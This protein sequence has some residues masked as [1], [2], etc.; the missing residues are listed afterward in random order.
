MVVGMN[1]GSKLGLVRRHPRAV[2]WVGWKLARH[3][4][5]TAT[6]IK[7]ARVAPQAARR[8]RAAAADPRLQGHVYEGRDALAAARDRVRRSDDLAGVLADEKLWS[9]LRRAAAA[10]A[11]GYAV[12]QSPQPKRR[13]RLRRVVLTVGVIGAGAYAGYRATRQP[14]QPD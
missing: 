14:D 8:A 7:V 9:E 11:A 2:A 12:A 6:A 4:Q 13:H 5:R 1:K 3:P 10:M